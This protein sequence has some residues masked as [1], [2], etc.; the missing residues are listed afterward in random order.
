MADLKPSS[1]E[2]YG[3]TFVVYWFL[4]TKWMYMALYSAMIASI[5]HLISMLVAYFRVRRKGYCL[6]ILIFTIYTFISAFF[7]TFVLAISV[8]FT[9]QYI[10]YDP[11]DIIIYWGIGFG[12]LYIIIKVV[13]TGWLK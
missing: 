6:F 5:I 3:E 4:E 11:S 8:S 7:Y 13:T 2:N 10:K 12:I 9:Y 1:D